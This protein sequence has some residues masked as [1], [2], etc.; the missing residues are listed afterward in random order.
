VVVV[1]VVLAVSVDVSAVVVLIATEVGERAHVAGLVALEGVL[2]IEHD[3]VTVPVNEL[4]GVTV[5]VDVPLALGLTFMLPLF[6]TVKL[7]LL[8]LP[9][10]CQKSP[11]PARSGAAASSNHAHFPILIAAPLCIFQAFPCFETRLQGIAWARILSCP[12]PDAHTQF[13]PMQEETH[14]GQDSLASSPALRVVLMM[15]RLINSK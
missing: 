4:P 1:D 6:V 12:R 5:M 3:S 15:P 8:L 2:V 13:R 9:G 14:S 11:Q 10:A 7:V